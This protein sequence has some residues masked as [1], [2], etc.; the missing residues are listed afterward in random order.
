MLWGA[1]LGSLLFL[2]PACRIHEGGVRVFRPDVGIVDGRHMGRRSRIQSSL[3]GR[4][5]PAWP[6]VWHI[7][8][9]PLRPRS[10]LGEFCLAASSCLGGFRWL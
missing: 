3:L 8:I 4:P 7:V 6:L 10:C 5:L 9:V 1:S 2:S